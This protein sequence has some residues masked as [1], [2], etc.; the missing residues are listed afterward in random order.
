MDPREIKIWKDRGKIIITFTTVHVIQNIRS[1]R[2]IYCRRTEN[3]LRH[4]L[5]HAHMSTQ[6]ITYTLSHAHKYT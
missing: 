6:V 5:L 1:E 4:S 2:F 3:Y